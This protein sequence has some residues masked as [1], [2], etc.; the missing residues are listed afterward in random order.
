M[1]TYIS[2]SYSKAPEI[3]S[4]YKDASWLKLS[5]PMVRDGLWTCLIERMP[6]RRLR[7]H[8]R[9]RRGAQRLQ[10]EANAALAEDWEDGGEGA[11]DEGISSG[12]AYDFL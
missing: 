11:G 6:C 9:A 12:I 4:Y 5:P 7:L 3:R 8:P 2:L 10:G 1:K